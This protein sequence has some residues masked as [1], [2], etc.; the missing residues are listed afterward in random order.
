MKFYDRE[1]EKVDVLPPK[2][3]GEYTLSLRGLSIED[4]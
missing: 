4:M 3:F 1:S 2:S